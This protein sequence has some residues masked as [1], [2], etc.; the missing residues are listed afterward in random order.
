MQTLTTTAEATEFEASADA[1][2]FG[3]FSSDD[4]AEA[5]TYMKAAGGIDRLSFATTSTK[6]VLE[7]YGASEGGKIVVMKTYDE[8]KAELEVTSSTTE[9]RLIRQTC[10]DMR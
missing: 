4:S 10:F 2:V 3:L 7:A 9:V 5:K 6:E 1:V 8:K